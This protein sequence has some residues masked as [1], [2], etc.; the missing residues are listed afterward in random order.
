MARWARHGLK[1]TA[2]TQANDEAAKRLQGHC[3][4]ALDLAGRPRHRWKS[5]ADG[6]FTIGSVAIELRNGRQRMVNPHVGRKRW[7]E[8]PPA[9]RKPARQDILL[10]L[11]QGTPAYVSVLMFLRPV[12]N[13]HRRDAAAP[14]GQTLEEGTQGRESLRQAASTVE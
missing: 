2:C 8:D 4:A 14:D 5:G 9:R 6:G 3:E 11:S 7:K 10:N 1:L 13:I 12:L